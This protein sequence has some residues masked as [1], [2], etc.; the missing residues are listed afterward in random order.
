M[1]D[2]FF[3]DGPITPPAA[4]LAGAEAHHLIHVLRAKPGLVVTLFDGGG[5]EYGAHVVRIGRSE[6][7]LAIDE[8]REL[9]RELPVRVTLGVSLP[10]QER[11]RWL[12]EKAVELGVA[13][14]VPLMARRSVA[15]PSAEALDRMR[16]VVVEASKQCGRNRLMEI[17]PGQSPAE[18]FRSFAAAHPRW[19]AHPGG[20]SLAAAFSQ[21]AQSPRGQERMAGSP[22]F[23]IALAIGPEGG[24]ADEEVAAAVPYGWQTVDLGARI[25]RIETAACGLAAIAAL[26]AAVE[27]A[28]GCRAAGRRSR[29]HSSFL[30]DFLPSGSVFCSTSLFVCF[31]FVWFFDPAPQ[32][33]AVVAGAPSAGVLSAVDQHSGGIGPQ[34]GN[35]QVGQR[36]DGRISCPFDRERQ[37]QG[38]IV[39][40]INDADVEL[41]DFAFEFRYFRNRVAIF[42]RSPAPPIDRVMAGERCTGE[43]QRKLL[44]QLF[45]GWR[46]LGRCGPFCRRRSWAMGSG[47]APQIGEAIRQPSAQD[48]APV[49]SISSRRSPRFDCN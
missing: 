32:L 33:A 24:F 39:L 2:R 34:T 13:R 48:K 17:A 44:F 46:G 7:E 42:A 20:L 29:N 22:R 49:G 19:L 18:F 21:A 23:E 41:P 31:V 9:D 8:R 28:L 26:L 12:V 30:S 14:L 43:G 4:T 38:H 27:M 25:L 37:R 15:Q 47:S 3:V 40:A 45:L 35:R 36:N 16:R 10:K 6:V 11:Q 5:A 1:A